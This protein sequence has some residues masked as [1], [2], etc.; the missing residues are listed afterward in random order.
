[1]DILYGPHGRVDLREREVAAPQLRDLSFL[2]M[3][4][5]HQRAIPIPK[6]F[7]QSRKLCVLRPL[8]LIR[9]LVMSSCNS[10]V[11]AQIVAS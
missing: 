5:S 4:L 9:R 8:P 3:S 6:D 7:N 2:S 11:I 1:V 10:V